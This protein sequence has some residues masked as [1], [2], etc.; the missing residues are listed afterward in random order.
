MHPFL[1]KLYKLNVKPRR[2]PDIKQSYIEIP[3][4]MTT[5]CALFWCDTWEAELKTPAALSKRHV[6]PQA[7]SCWLLKTHCSFHR[8]LVECSLTDIN[9]WTSDR[10]VWCLSSFNMPKRTRERF[11]D[12]PFTSIHLFTPL[13]FRKSFDILLLSVVTRGRH[14]RV[15]WL[16]MIY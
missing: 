9:G 1:W 5:P 6:C 16:G 8:D 7:F 15:I 10:S 12:I 4:C 13:L 11:T 14:C 3:L 2:L